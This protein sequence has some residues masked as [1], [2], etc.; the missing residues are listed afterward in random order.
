MAHEITS[1]DNMFSVREMPWHGLGDV[2]EDYPTRT[3][4]QPLVH[5]WEPVATPLYR[6]VPQINAE[7]EPV[8][9]YEEVDTH[10][11]QERSDNG[12]LLGVTSTTYTA[13]KNDEMWDVAEALQGGGSDVMYETAGSLRG[14]S[15]VWLMLR[16]TDPITIKGDPRGA[17]LPFYLL[18]NA[19]DGTAAFRGSATN[20]RVV[21]AN[22][23][24]AADLDAQSRGTEFTFHHTKSITERIE[25]ARGAL[26]GWRESVEAYRLLGEHMVNEPVSKAAER[27]FLERFI[28]APLATMTTDR[29]KRNIEE[30][31]QQWWDVYNSQTNEGITGTAWGLLQASSEWSEHIRR[32]ESQ[33]TRFR[34]AVLNRNQ[35]IEVAKR[36]ALEAAHA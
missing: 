7:G 19:H 24:R 12:H 21:C 1:T 13:V 33:E 3:E 29:V 23:M 30:A 36:I 31:R 32:A 4:A 27:E 20:V 8:V 18:Q 34:R 26:S 28:P 22:T 11:A 17:M 25:E 5:D 6:A 14:G 35:V 2:L 9:I 10:V 16:L 15:Q